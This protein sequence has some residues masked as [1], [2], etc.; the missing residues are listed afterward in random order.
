MSHNN[1]F[2]KNKK[3]H[4]KPKEQTHHD[5]EDVKKEWFAMR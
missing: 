3:K 4:A 2:N 5:Q 1:P